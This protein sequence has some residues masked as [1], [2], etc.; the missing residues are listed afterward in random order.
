MPC[1]PT[2]SPA[3]GTPVRDTASQY[4]SDHGCNEMGHGG[5]PRRNGP[6]RPARSRTG[7]TRCPRSTCAGCETSY[8]TDAG[9]QWTYPQPSG[10]DTLRTSCGRGAAD[11]RRAKT[12]NGAPRESGRSPPPAR[13]SGAAM[14]RSKFTKSPNATMP[15][16]LARTVLRR[17]GESGACSRDGWGREPTAAILK[18]PVRADAAT[19]AITA[20]FRWETAVTSQICSGSWRET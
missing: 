12:T 11:G 16:T 1:G 7:T 18:R 19:S 13:T 5:I 10:V 9:K 15:T 4:T 17:H 3:D 8:R 20:R 14:P 6:W 2:R